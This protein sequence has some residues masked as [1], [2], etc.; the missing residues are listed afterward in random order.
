MTFYITK[1]ADGFRA[2][3]DEA[4][5]DVTVRSA[6]G[7]VS[8]ALFNNGEEMDRFFSITKKLLG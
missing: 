3:F 5:I 1:P 7:R 6:Q 8:P 4:K 2:A